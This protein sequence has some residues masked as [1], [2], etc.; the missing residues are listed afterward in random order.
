MSVT[1]FFPHPALST[2]SLS[3]S[4]SFCISLQ[5][6][7]H[8]PQSVCCTRRYPSRLRPPQCV[9]GDERK[10]AI[11]QLGHT[12]GR[13]T[14]WL[15]PAANELDAGHAEDT[16]WSLIELPPLLY[17]EAEGKTSSSCANTF[18]EPDIIATTVV[19]RNRFTFFNAIQL[20]SECVCVCVH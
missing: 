2:V 10:S 1:Y 19:W 4:L 18:T 14:A 5:L 9:H 13:R 16:L 7:H 15:R 6:I 17:A 3:L 11:F 12:A 20:R 8:S